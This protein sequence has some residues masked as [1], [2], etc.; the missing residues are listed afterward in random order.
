MT[1]VQFGWRFSGK[2]LDSDEVDATPVDARQ[3]GIG[4][5]LAV[6]VQPLRVLTGEGL[7]ELDELHQFSGLVGAGQ[8]RV[9]VAQDAAVMLL[10][11]EAED[12]GI[13]LAPLGD[14]VRV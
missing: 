6:E 14:V 4:D 1:S 12:T 10:S 7:P 9:G 2:L 5:D 3:F 11:E 8:I 13:G